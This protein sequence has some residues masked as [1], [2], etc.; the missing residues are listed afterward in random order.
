MKNL[1]PIPLVLED[2]NG[3]VIRSFNWSQS[4]IYLVQKTKQSRLEAF[5]DTSSI[6]SDF[7]SYELIKKIDL[8]TIGRKKL[9]L[10][11]M[12]TLRVIR[13]DEK[14]NINSSEKLNE[15][16]DESFKKTLRWSTY[17]HLALFILGLSLFWGQKL[18]F[19][20]EETLVKIEIP[21]KVQIEPVKKQV[22]KASKKKINKTKKVVRNKT[23]V[24]P[25]VHQRTRKSVSQ[26]G[27]LGALGGLSNGSKSGKGLKLD[28]AL[29]HTGS[30][31][32]SGTKSL[33]NAT[34]SF[35]GKALSSGSGGNGSVDHGTVGYGTKGLS[36]GQSGY[37]KHN[38]GGAGGSY[39]HPMQEEGDVDGGLEMSQIEAVIQQNIGQ[40][41]YCYEKGLQSQPQLNGRV[42]VNFLI[43]GSGRVQMAQVGRSSLKAASVEKCM[44]GKIKNWKF[45]K[46]HGNVDV[47]VSYPFTLKRARHG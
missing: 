3:K 4:N 26:L 9:V 11:E 10:N 22:V 28:S 8:E 6:N 43:N 45:P 5:A 2:S 44:T 30:G 21:N 39:E 24:K 25:I 16:E 18:F 40:I 29:T 17:F 38:I 23:K 33:G 46:P 37:G 41:F 34:T 7:K 13:E 42:A 31:D 36:G 14:L 12:A 1:K 20:K 15:N 27:A 47:N 19:E 35:A 32:S